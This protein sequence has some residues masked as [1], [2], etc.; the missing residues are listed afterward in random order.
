MFSTQVTLIKRIGKDNFDFN[1]PQVDRGLLNNIFKQLNSGLIGAL[2]EK[3]KFI[4]LTDPIGIRIIVLREA[5]LVAGNYNK[6]TR[7][8]GQTPWM[9]KGETICLSSVQEEMEKVLMAVF[10]GTQVFLHAGG[11]ED[12][13]VRM[14]GKGRP[15]ILSIMNAKKKES[16]N[17]EKQM[18][19]I[20]ETIAKTSKYIKVNS[21][22]MV[23]KQ[24]MI[25]IKGYEESKEKVYSALVWSEKEVTE[26]DIKILNEVDNLKIIQNTPFR[27][28]HRRSPIMREKMI[29]ILKAKRLGKH[30]MLVKVDSS[31]GTYIKEFIHG[32][33]GRTLPNVGTLIG[34][35]C[36]ILQLDVDDINYA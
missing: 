14:L 34:S 27:V 16:L 31:A 21:L 30:F 1:N 13:D 19:L 6:Y 32:D 29:L 12:R 3:A 25:D 17:N 26:E 15:F 23:D 18:Q 28:L 24:Y 36:D 7:E 20:E 33:L 2:L 22:R 5:V 9:V 4:N 8:I 10:E 11:R 35:R